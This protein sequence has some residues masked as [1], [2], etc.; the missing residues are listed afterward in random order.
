MLVHRK[1]NVDVLRRLS[2]QSFGIN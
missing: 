2:N 1:W